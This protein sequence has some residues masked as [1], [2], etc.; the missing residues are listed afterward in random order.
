[1]KMNLNKA[2]NVVHIQQQKSVS[3][4]KNYLLCDYILIF[5]ADIAFL[6]SNFYSL[7]MTKYLEMSLRNSTVDFL[8]SENQGY[9]RV[10]S[11]R[12]QLYL[13]FAFYCKFF[14]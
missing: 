5:P 9:N 4:E 2:K 3:F 10:C 8:L 14:W 13:V 11:K 12:N 1:M 6:M 7:T